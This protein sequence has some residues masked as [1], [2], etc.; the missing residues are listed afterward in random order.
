VMRSRSSVVLGGAVS[1]SAREATAGSMC[2]LN[3]LPV[4]L[5]ASTSDKS[6]LE[7]VN[8][9][10]EAS[11]SLAWRTPGRER[12]REAQL[13]A[14][15]LH[16]NAE[17]CHATREHRQLHCCSHIC[18]EEYSPSRQQRSRMIDES[19]RQCELQHAVRIRPRLLYVGLCDTAVQ[20]AV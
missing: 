7:S 13:T 16:F 14:R 2:A 20:T 1:S 8:L 3:T 17:L 11:V 10:A 9:S 6:G 4:A 19:V 18:C 12:G 15:L 5:V